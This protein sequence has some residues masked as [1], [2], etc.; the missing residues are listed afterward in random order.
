MAVA[1]WSLVDLARNVT[2]GG[3]EAASGARHAR[4]VNA[5]AQAPLRGTGYGTYAE[6]VRMHS[7]DS[8]TAAPVERRNC[9]TAGQ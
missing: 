1:A 3:F 6:I 9:R 2:P 8:G 7:G 4:I 5:I